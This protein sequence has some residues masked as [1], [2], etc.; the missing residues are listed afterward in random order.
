LINSWYR[1]MQ[2]L[3]CVKFLCFKAKNFHNDLP[4]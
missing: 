1:I 2:T 4:A 3:W